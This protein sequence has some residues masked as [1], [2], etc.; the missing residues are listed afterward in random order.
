MPKTAVLVLAAGASRRMGRPKQLLPYKGTTFL[1]HT[2]ALAKT[3]AQEVLVVLG[4]NAEYIKPILPEKI[5]FVVNADWE[6]GMGTSIALGVKTLVE[7]N[8]PEALLVLLVDQPL[9]D[10]SYLKKMLEEG[11][12]HPTKIIATAYGKRRGVPTIFSHTHFKKLMKLNADYGAKKYMAQLS[13][14]IVVLDAKD[15]VLDIDTPEKY[16]DLIASD[17]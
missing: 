1:G 14:E 9:I 13:E 17:K 6:K 16:A 3:V 12:K 15:K 10:A 5:D 8:S 11:R 4:A 7:K 2:I